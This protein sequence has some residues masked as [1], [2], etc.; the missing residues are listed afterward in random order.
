[1]NYFKL[2]RA[3][4]IV[5][6]FVHAT[7]GYSMEKE[8]PDF[9][10]EKIETDY[11][12]KAQTNMGVSYIFIQSSQILTF[13]TLDQTYKVVPFTY[14]PNDTSGESRK[15]L[16]RIY[17]MPGFHIL[18]DL[19]PSLNDNDEL[20]CNGVL[21]ISFKDVNSD[22]ANDII[23]LYDFTTSGNKSLEPEAVVY[24][25]EPASQKFIFN[26]ALSIKAASSRIRNM[27]DVLGNLKKK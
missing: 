15:C 10:S 18:Q 6:L 24:V 20:P 25:Y 14:M 27:K 9:V 16:I 19:E 17:K 12:N 23:A 5:G 21:S 7:S 4:C 3:F 1:M 8:L 2:I 13:K 11:Q 26:Q 22:K